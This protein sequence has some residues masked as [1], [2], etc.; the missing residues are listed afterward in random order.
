MPTFES[1]FEGVESALD[2]LDKRVR[3]LQGRMRRFRAAAKTG[4]L[5]Q[6]QD[7]QSKLGADRQTVNSA[8]GTVCDA[9]PFTDASELSYLR[10]QYAAELVRVAGEH[11]VDIFERDSRLVAF[12][13]LLRI[14][15]AA[16]KVRVNRKQLAT[17]RPSALVG[18][19]KALQAKGAGFNAQAFITVLCRA[20]RIHTRSDS[21]G[22][23]QVG[24]QDIHETLTL[25]P[26]ARKEY[27]LTEFG[28]DL[29]LLDE[30]G[31]RIA[32]VERTVYELNWLRASTSSKGGRFVS[33]VDRGGQQIGYAAI[34]F[35]SKDA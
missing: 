25:L 30:S 9:W 32:T 11:G 17:L 28:R 3:E 13:A 12:P 16:R 19:L 18:V 35:R 20:W 26:M 2:E 29:L 22:T 4:D 34:E 31:V 10:D 27:D 5:R 24:L 15:A 33:T 23:R 1:G 14:D 8:I 21:S 6:M 7:S